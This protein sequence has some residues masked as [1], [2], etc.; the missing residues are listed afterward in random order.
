MIPRLMIGNSNLHFLDVFSH[1]AAWLS[2]LTL[3]AL[4][5]VLGVD[6]LVFVAL[7]TQGLAP[8]KQALAGRLGLG[9]AVFF[10]LVLLS[11]LFWLTRLVAPMFSL[12]GHGFSGRDLILLLGGFFLL[13]KATAEIHAEIEPSDDES[14]GRPG[15]TIVRAIAQIGLLDI[16]FSLDSVLTAIGMADDLLIMA[17]AVIIAVGIMIWASGPVGRFIK[18]HPT[19]KMLALGFL[20][21]IGMTLVADGCGTPVPK[22]FIYAAIGFSLLVEGLNQWARRNRS[23][24]K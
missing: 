18:Q 8:E 9:L 19:V 2:L 1:P 6:N 7:A 24:R 10:R 13:Y 23:A 16:V 12:H 3:T 17:S 11:S 15:K 21:L 14:E 20:L 5:I 4:E 22:G